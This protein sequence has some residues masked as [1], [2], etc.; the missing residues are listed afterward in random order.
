MTTMTGSHGSDLLTGT[1]G[2]GTTRS[3]IGDDAVTGRT[4]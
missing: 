1:A 2:S 4:K 3:D